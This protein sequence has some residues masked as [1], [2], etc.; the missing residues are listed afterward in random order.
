MTGDDGFDTDSTGSAAYERAG[1][2]L[3]IPPLASKSKSLSAKRLAEEQ[4]NDNADHDE[5]VA[6]GLDDSEMN[7]VDTDPTADVSREDQ[8]EDAEDGDVSMDGDNDDGRDGDAQAVFFDDAAEDESGPFQ[9]RG[10]QD[11]IDE[12]DS[13]QGGDEGEDEEEEVVQPPQKRRRIGSRR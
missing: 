11:D 4:E 8:Q 7:E 2:K 10:S 3:D 6:D 12:L 13:Q 9:H 1:D 5:G